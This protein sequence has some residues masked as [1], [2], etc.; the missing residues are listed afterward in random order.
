M[1]RGTKGHKLISSIQ[2]SDILPPTI[3]KGGRGAV[4]V[5]KAQA[6]PRSGA[7]VHTFEGSAIKGQMVALAVF[8]DALQFSRKCETTNW[9]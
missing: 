7:H 1:E 3:S 9:E 8:A 4:H 5:C 2:M 6:P